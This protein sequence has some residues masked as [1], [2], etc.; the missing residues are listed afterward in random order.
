MI[1]KLSLWLIEHV[2]FLPWDVKQ[3]VV[4]LYSILITIVATFVWHFADFN[5]QYLWQALAGI[6]TFGL[7]ILA[8][9]IALFTRKWN[10]WFWIPSV[11]GVVF[12][13]FLMFL[14]FF[15]FGWA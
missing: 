9:I 2:S 3:G 1:K 4:F 7:P 6:V 13:G 12:G 10:P 11:I 8:G 5:W 14:V 15:A